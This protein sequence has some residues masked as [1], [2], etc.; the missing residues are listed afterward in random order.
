MMVKTFDDAAFALKV[1]EISELVRSDFGYHI[2]KL[3]GIKPSRVL[4]F[5]EAREGIA[6]K[7]RQQK[8]L[9]NF[10]ALAEKFSNAVYEQSDTLKPAAELVGGKIEQSAWLSKGA[11]VGAPWTPKMLDAIFTDDVTKRKR[12]TA[13]IEIEPNTLLAARL[14]EYK[15]ATVSAFAE[16]QAAV[17]QKLLQNRAQELAVKQGKEMLAALQAGIAKPTLAWSATQNLTR[18]KPGTLDAAL[19]RQVFQAD[20]A[21]LPQYV[22]AE[23]QQNGYTIVRVDAVKEGESAN[24]ADRARYVQQIRKLSGEEL[25]HAYLED[26]KQH[27][28]IKVNLPDVVQP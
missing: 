6:N 10:A 4:P 1:G 16:V 11:N 2:I 24:E 13:A 7:L 23:T 17:R 12:N 25:F 21:K 27:V 20:A 28:A 9:D 26:A 8:A 15:P 5:D 19:L 14:L 18:A 3:A 22:G